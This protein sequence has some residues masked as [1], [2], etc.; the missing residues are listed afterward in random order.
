VHFKT[1]SHN[2]HDDFARAVV[3]WITTRMQVIHHRQLHEENEVWV[4][5]FLC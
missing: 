4:M 5:S 2:R 3:T 1:L